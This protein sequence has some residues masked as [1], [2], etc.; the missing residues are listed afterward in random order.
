MYRCD[1]RGLAKLS[2]GVMT[3]NGLAFSPDGRTLYFSDTPRFV[4][5]RFDYDRRQGKRKRREFIRIEPTATDR[6]RPMGAAVDAEVAIGRPVR[7]KQGRPIRSTGQLMS[8]TRTRTLRNDAGVWWSDM[9]TLFVT[10]AR[11]K[12]AAGGWCREHRPGGG[13]GSRRLLPSCRVPGIPTPF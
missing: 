1:T 11:D 6:G 2:E 9:K 12:N 5:Y 10:T 8:T 3:S 7:R 4:V 13:L